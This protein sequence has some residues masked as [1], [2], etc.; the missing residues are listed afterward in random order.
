MLI[1]FRS[2]IDPAI[3]HLLM[4]FNTAGYLPLTRRSPS[5]FVV[6]KLEFQKRRELLLPNAHVFPMADDTAQTVKA[7]VNLELTAT[8]HPATWLEAPNPDKPIDR[9]TLPATIALK[10]V[11]VA[12]KFLWT[13]GIAVAD[14]NVDLPPL[15]AEPPAPSPTV[16][17][18]QARVYPP[19]VVPA[20]NGLIARLEAARDRQQQMQARRRTLEHL[21]VNR[22]EGLWPFR[23]VNLR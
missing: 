18:L 4:R 13:A 7:D 19:P 11:D 21:Q 3:E 14:I 16:R 6:S 15:P 1:T 22:L 8:R 12:T 9:I 2:P 5:T 23:S 20:P 10:R 17:A